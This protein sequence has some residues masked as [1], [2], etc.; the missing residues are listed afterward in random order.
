MSHFKSVYDLLSKDETA[1]AHFAPQLNMIQELMLDQQNELD[2]LKSNKVKL[3][4]ITRDFK[5]MNA[6][7][8][9]IDAQYKEI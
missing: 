2:V 3:E 7:G 6:K 5:E 4:K 8:L 1:I 9:V